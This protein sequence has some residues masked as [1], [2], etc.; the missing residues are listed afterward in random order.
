MWFI[1]KSNPYAIDGP[2]DV[3]KTLSCLKNFNAEEKNIAKKSIQR[4]AF[5]GHPE[6]KKV[7]K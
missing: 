7:L 3:L 5:F 4:N 2:N 6:Q 1:I